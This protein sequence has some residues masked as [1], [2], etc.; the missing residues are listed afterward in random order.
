MQQKTYLDDILAFHRERSSTDNRSFAEL[1]DLALQKNTPRDFVTAINSQSGLSVIAEIKRRS[2]SKGNL[3]IELDPADMA[4]L[5]QSAGASCISVLTDTEFF[6]G[7]RQDLITARSA[8]ELPIL[9][10]DF[11]IDKRDICDARLMGA[12]C[13]LLIVAALNDEELSEFLSITEELGMHALVE[14]HDER[15]VGRALNAGANLI[16]VNQRDLV[17]FEVDQ[18]RAIRVIKE[19]PESV[20]RIAESGIRGLKD[21]STLAE[22]GYHAVLV[23]EAFVTST[24]PA[25]L[26][27]ALE[28]I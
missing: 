16:G 9:R 5:Y 17:T 13:V 6:S 21:A 7:S 14:A 18:E 8:T 10:K 12:D 1:F 22:A 15:E 4:S 26:I 24:D 27:S 19:I 23:G 2:P 28:G 20:T 3:K 11:T 25:T